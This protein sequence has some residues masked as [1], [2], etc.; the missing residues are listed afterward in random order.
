MDGEFST[1][2]E[3][4]NLLIDRGHSAQHFRVIKQRSFTENR[5][6]LVLEVN[7]SARTLY[8]SHPHFRH[9]LGSGFALDVTDASA[10]DAVPDLLFAARPLVKASTPLATYS[11]LPATSAWSCQAFELNHGF[12]VG[13]GSIQAEL[14]HFT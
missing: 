8:Q 2:S 12:R 9:L 3:F 10:L 5:L 7:D 4:L 13:H 14:W 11:N 1:G 6:E